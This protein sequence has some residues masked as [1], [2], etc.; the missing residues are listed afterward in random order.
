MAAESFRR[1]D[2]PGVISKLVAGAADRCARRPWERRFRAILPCFHAVVQVGIC[3]WISSEVTRWRRGG[4]FGRSRRPLFLGFLWGDLTGLEMKTPVLELIETIR[5]IAV[6]A[7]RK[8]K[9]ESNPKN[10]F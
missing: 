8:N 2:L 4:V 6:S 9:K 1:L 10:V 5:T 3:S 7:V